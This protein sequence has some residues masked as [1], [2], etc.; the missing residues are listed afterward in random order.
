MCRKGMNLKTAEKN[1]LEGVC[2]QGEDVE[3]LLLLTSGDQNFWT[4]VRG[5]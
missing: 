1:V 3:I 2:A 5:G 4:K